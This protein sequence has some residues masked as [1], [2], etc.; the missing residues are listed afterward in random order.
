MRSRNQ[1]VLQHHF[2]SQCQTVY[3]PVHMV[4]RAKP[5]RSQDGRLVVAGMVGLDGGIL[6]AGGESEAV[7]TIRLEVEPPLS[8]A[9]KV[10]QYRAQAS[11]RSSHCQCH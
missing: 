1:I 9:G 8:S 5:R 7:A 4:R 3:F 11:A 10:S 2:K 6:A